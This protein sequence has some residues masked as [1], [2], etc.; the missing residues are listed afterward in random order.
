MMDPHRLLDAR[1]AVRDRLG[2]EIVW[3]D[4]VRPERDLLAAQGA[5]VGEHLPEPRV[6]GHVVGRVFRGDDRVGRLA[7][8][9]CVSPLTGAAG[10]GGSVPVECCQIC[11]H[12]KLETVLSLEAPADLEGTG[13]GLAYRLYE[14]LGILPRN[15]VSEEVKG[16]D[17]EARAAL[18]NLGVRFGAYHLTVPALLKPAPRSLAAQ[19]WALKHGGPEV[20]HWIPVRR[21]EISMRP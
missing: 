8:V 19:L 13:R 17:Q 4:E 2:V 6:L 20:N 16:L 1:L 14:N 7:G 11:G 5:R 21:V 9:H 15:A 10:T 3:K 18:R 12:E